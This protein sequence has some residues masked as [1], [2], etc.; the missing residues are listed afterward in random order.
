METLIDRNGI[1]YTEEQIENFTE[2]DQDDF[3][4]NIY[5]EVILTIRKYPKR[6]LIAWEVDEAFDLPYDPIDGEDA[7]R[8]YIPPKVYLWPERYLHPDFEARRKEI[9][10]TIKTYLQERYV[11]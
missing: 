5:P 4:Y 3:D 11:K 7:A 6:Y 10:A 9:L 2:V 1:P 8:C